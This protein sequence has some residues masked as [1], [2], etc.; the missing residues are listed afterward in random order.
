MSI[1]LLKVIISDLN[2]SYSSECETVRR[3]IDSERG[4]D[5]S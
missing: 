1:T 4:D 5:A 3:L 2:K